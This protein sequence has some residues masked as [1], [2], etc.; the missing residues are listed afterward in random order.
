MADALPPCLFADFDLAGWI[1][2]PFGVVLLVIF[3]L[4]AACW[5]FP[6]Y[7]MRVFLWLVSHTVYRIRV[8]G[9]ENVPAT[10][11]ALLVCNHV[12]YIDWLLLLAAQR[13]FIRFV[14]FA[15]YAR[16]WLFRRVLRWAG[17]IPIDAGAGPRAIVEALRAAADAVAG[18]ELVCIFAEGRFTR[19][20]FMLPFAR[21]FEQVVKHVRAPIVPVC[22]DQVWGSIFSFFGGRIFRKWPQE[23]PYHVWVAF[24]APLPPETSAG[25]VRQAIQ[26]LSAD[27]AI[28]RSPERQLVHRRFVRVAARHPFRSCVIDSS[29]KGPALT[30]GKTLA[31]AICFVNVLRPILGNETMVAVWLPPGLG[32]LLTNAALALLGKTSVNLNYSA[33]REVVQSAV[34][35]CGARHVITVRRFD[36]RVKIDP[37]PGVE[38]VYLEDLAPRITKFQRLAAYL[39]VLLLPG[40]W[41]EHITLKLGKHTIDDLATII[42]SSGSTGEPKGVMLTHN[43]IA[44]NVESMIQGASLTY[45]DR[46][47]GVLPFFHSFGYAVTLWAP[48]QIGASSVYHADPRAAREIGELCRTHLCTLFVTTPTFLRFCLKKC[49]ENDFKSLRLLVTGAE[50]LPQS[51]A[52]DFEKRSA[53]F[54]WK[55]MAARSCRRSWASTCPTSRSTATS[56]SATA[57]ARSASRCRA[58]P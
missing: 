31:G 24:G 51:L 29:M 25:D 2:S 38:L 44:A 12:S 3:A 45:R 15:G 5:L 26:A 49:E 10:G 50:K 53:C 21:G 28:A 57:P 30:Y 19:T 6:Y 8:V 32:G 27:C 41:L 20:G 39:R 56:R 54:R 14:I 48:L 58:S 17:V 4:V 13:R 1:T 34:K 52:Q 42:F 40:V 16:M 43:N 18:G 36:Q 22:L 23:I 9:K 33:S 11:G 46:L 55:V 37:G 35:Q 47:L 7:A